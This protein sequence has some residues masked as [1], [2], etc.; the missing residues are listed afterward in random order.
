M[1]SI[2]QTYREKC[3]VYYIIGAVQV[4]H[5]STHIIKHNN[6]QMLTLVSFLYIFGLYRCTMLV[7]I[8][9][10]FEKMIYL[11]QLYNPETSQYQS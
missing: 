10:N 8:I 1:Y 11:F 7:T 3:T 5:L 2:E 9:F 6:I 4:V